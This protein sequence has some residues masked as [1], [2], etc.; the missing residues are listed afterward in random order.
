MR[1]EEGR[2][3]KELLEQYEDREIRNSEMQAECEENQFEPSEHFKE[4]MN[5]LLENV[6]RHRRVQWRKKLQ[7]FR[8]F[9]CAKFAKS[10]ALA[11][12]LVLFTGEVL[13]N[14]ILMASVNQIVQNPKKEGETWLTFS[15]INPKDSNELRPVSELAIEFQY[16]PDGYE[17]VS[18]Q[19]LSG[20]RG[21]H[22]AKDEENNFIVVISRATDLANN[23]FY[24]GTQGYSVFQA[25]TIPVTKM[26][27]ET[28]AIYVWMQFDYLFMISSTEDFQEEMEELIASIQIS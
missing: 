21:F 25:G 5:Q 8:V 14:G 22:Y 18:E 9:T 16:T 7:G 24:V 28:G 10:V 1:N 13:G 27:L 12:L 19:S 26:E 20:G 4:A 23:C 3:I 6:P 11:V 17:F 15:V 2:K